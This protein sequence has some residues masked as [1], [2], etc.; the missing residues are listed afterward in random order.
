MTGAGVIDITISDMPD[1]MTGRVMGIGSWRG[2]VR[3]AVG[4]WVS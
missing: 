1:R 3:Q 2:R 4:R